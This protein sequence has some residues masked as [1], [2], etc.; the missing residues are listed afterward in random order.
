V[1]ADQ[2]EAFMPYLP[3]EVV[4]PVAAFLAHESCP[5]N[6]EV[7]VAG[8]G[9]VQRLAVVETQGINHPNLTPEHVAEHLDALLDMTEARL[10]AVQAEVPL[11]VQS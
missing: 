6:G 3:P 10:V 2:I 8:G 7:L 1:P 5:L 9:R 4:S 11:Q